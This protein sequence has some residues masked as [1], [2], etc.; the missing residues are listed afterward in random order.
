MRQLFSFLKDERGISVEYIAIAAL[1]VAALYVVWTK[2][3]S[4][5]MQDYTSR[6]GQMLDEQGSTLGQ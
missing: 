4:P 5:K 3:V 6:Y 1:A 2:I